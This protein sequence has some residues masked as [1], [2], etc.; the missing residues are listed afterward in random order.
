MTASDFSLFIGRLHPLLV[1]LPI[2]FV[3][4]LAALELI[5]RWTGRREANAAAGWVLALAVPA[6]AGAA[7]CGW[8]LS[9]AGGYDPHLLQW[10]KWTGLGTAAACL[11]AALLYRCD[12]HR[13]YRLCL[14]VTVAAL[15]VASHFGGSLTHGSDYLV[16]Y[17]PTPV[18]N[19][20]GG[21][22]RP[23]PATASKPASLAETPV[24]SGVIAPILEPNCLSCHGPAKAKAGLRL[25]TPAALRRGSEHGA[26]MVAGESGE[27]TLIRRIKLPPE[28]EDH[29]PPEGKPQPSVDDV[30]LLQWWI[31]AGAPEDAKVSELRPP[32]A[33]LQILEQRFG[34]APTTAKL[35]P[36]RPLREVQAIAG[37]LA[38]ELDIVITP[39]SPNAPWL[40]ANASL[41]RTN[42]DDAALARLAPIA[43]NLRWLDL[44]GTRV[45][46]AGLGSVATMP[47]L[48]RL[49]LERT[50]VS[51]AGL[52]QLATLTELD[53]LNL[54]GTAVTDTG[55]AALQH[56]PKLKQL[57][58]WQ[59]HVTP[60]AARAFASAKLDPQQTQ[61]WREEIEQLKAK[62]KDQAMTVDTGVAEPTNT[63]AAVK[64]VNTA[65]PVT[66][67]P[68]DPAKTVFYAGQLVAFCCDRCKAKF[69]KDP[70]PFLARLNLPA[71]NNPTPR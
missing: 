29:M 56:L 38:D 25:D 30:A 61:Q 59:T 52:A 14:A 11:L 24:F 17:A 64:P 37:Q 41:A 36:A 53:Y 4:L 33:I 32:A 16:R 26:V 28:N 7:G 63:T 54:Y 51:D 10:H 35:A 31:D 23:A 9:H 44:G 68:A 60:E 66:G 57:Y 12:C 48:A 34:L 49:H 1:H 67:T 13:L 62:I 55:L 50:A 42:F 20:F 46:D 27:S 2:G 58:L 43:L 19:W 18:R 45:T 8:L 3:L 6:A 40:Q 47:H 65:C 15:V 70:R 71:A 22:A 5:A 69:Q 21:P 39:L